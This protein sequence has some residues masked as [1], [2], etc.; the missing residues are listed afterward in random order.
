M[1][2]KQSE[3]SEAFVREMRIGLGVV[4]VLTVV[5]LYVAIGRLSGWY[6]PA[7]LAFEQEPK[8]IP[9]AAAPETAQRSDP[10][11]YQQA[12]TPP[13]TS[14][15][16]RFQPPE[17]VVDPV[18]QRST[19]TEPPAIVPTIEIP[20][21][22]RS[23]SVP[24][25]SG[26]EFSAPGN[27]FN[28]PPALPKVDTSRDAMSR[29]TPFAPDRLQPVNSLRQPA[30]P[31]P[32]AVTRRSP[33][34]PEDA[35]DELDDLELPVVELPP[36]LEMPQTDLPHTNLPQAELPQVERLASQLQDT[37]NMV[38]QASA[39]ESAVDKP[40][41]T[42]RPMQVL[43]KRDESFWSVAQRVYGDGR[44][45]HALFQANRNRI[46]TFNDL[47]PGVKL[48]TPPIEELQERWPEL[49]PRVSEDAEPV[50]TTTAAA[51]IH[52]T[53]EQESL[54][55]IAGERLGQASRYLEIY[56]LNRDLLPANVAPD[57]VLPAGLRL[58]LPD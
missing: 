54:F 40:I 44:Y 14:A 28:A 9:V 3:M 34:P 52:T 17:P 23:T 57:A 48:L 15:S 7:P 36:E 49:C 6:R 43:V 29:S 16:P 38:Q 39:V 27:E 33:E 32:Q 46:A 35:T 8:N 41:E 4:G 12:S 18:H 22:P 58:Q 19:S 10:V 11:Q 20:D 47:P 56:E 30:A 45:F 31:T 37:Q 1:P 53:G 21:R 50:S 42:P 25:I 51:G 26:S 2:S 5:F 24:A 13:A 55:E